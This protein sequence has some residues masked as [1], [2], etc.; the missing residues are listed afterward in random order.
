MLSALEHA[1]LKLR[2]LVLVLPLLLIAFLQFDDFSPLDAGYKI[3]NLF[4]RRVFG[5]EMNVLELRNS[6]WLK[7]I[8]ITENWYIR[9]FIPALFIG[10]RGS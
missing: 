8:F 9:M 5:Y 4:Q 10:M 2:E 7:T 6:L 1:V 3:L